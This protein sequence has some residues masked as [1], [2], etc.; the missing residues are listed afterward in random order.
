MH[1]NLLHVILVSIKITFQPHLLGLL[2]AMTIVFWM[3]IAMNNNFDV[4]RNKSKTKH[5][6]L[7]MNYSKKPS[8]ERRNLGKKA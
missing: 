7:H 2:L 5:K 6:N 4:S 8:T 1:T 3:V